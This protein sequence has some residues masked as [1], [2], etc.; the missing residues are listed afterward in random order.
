MAKITKE[1]VEYVAGLA[2]LSLDDAAKDRLVGEMGAILSYMDK[3][4]ELDTA[5]IEPMMHV[6]DITNVYREDVVGES[7]DRET[8]LMNAPKSDG[9]YFLV[10]RILDQE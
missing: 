1:D 10:P 4:N 2:R 9:E 3:L 7:L 5:G 6:L 8:A